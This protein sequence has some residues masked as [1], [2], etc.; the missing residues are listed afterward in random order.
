MNPL[1]TPSLYW[2]DVNYNIQVQI[3]RRDSMILSVQSFRPKLFKQFWIVPMGTSRSVITHYYTVRWIRYGPIY[4]YLRSVRTRICDS[5]IHQYSTTNVMHFL[6]NLLRIKILHMFRAL[7][8]HLQEALNKRHLV[9]C[10]RVMSVVCTRM[11]VATPILMQP[12]DITR[13]QYTKWRLYRDSWRWASNARNM[14]RVLILNK[15]N[16]KCITLILLYW[17]TTMHGH[18]TDILR[19]KVTLLIYYDARSLYWYTT[20]HGHYTDILRCTVTILIHYDARSLYWYTTMHGQQT[21]KHKTYY[22]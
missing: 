8:A 18:Y 19:C 14:W 3:R 20:I 17:Y 9:Y 21:V 11:G 13:K 6:F 2:H 7:F 15:L 5:I 22:L 12:T 1:H 10:M 4:M 16:T